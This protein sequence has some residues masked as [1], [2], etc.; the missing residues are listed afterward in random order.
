MKPATED[1][2]RK[3]V[4]VSNDLRFRGIEAQEEETKSK[5]PKILK[6]ICTPWF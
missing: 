2:H 5:I 3:V 6:L 1:G 4:Y